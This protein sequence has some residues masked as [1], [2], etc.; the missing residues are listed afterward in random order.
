MPCQIKMGYWLAAMVQS[1]L[2]SQPAEVKVASV[3]MVG[4][5]SPVTLAILPPLTPS[6]VPLAVVSQKLLEYTPELSKPRKPP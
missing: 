3:C 5:S 4:V 1:P 2:K 6:L